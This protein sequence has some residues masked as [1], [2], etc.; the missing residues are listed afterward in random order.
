MVAYCEV[1]SHITNSVYIV[2]ERVWESVCGG[3]GGGRTKIL[4]LNIG[5]T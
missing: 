5:I 2:K 3:G 1:S 4:K